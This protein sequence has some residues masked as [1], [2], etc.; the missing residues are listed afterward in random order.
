MSDSDW[1]ELQPVTKG[2]PVKVPV[3]FGLQKLGRGDGPAK[4]VLL[5]RR[6]CLAQLDLRHLRVAVRLGKGARAHQIALVP[7][8]DGPFEL[9][10]VGVAKGGGIYRLRL[11]PI[12]TF[13]DRAA[14]LI[15]RPFKIERDGKR[16]IIVVDLPSFCWDANARKSFEASR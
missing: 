4:G 10:E 12:D 11:P 6:D 2:A 3:R 1:T 13:P 8:D 5:I 9:Q 7:Q 16:Q 15:E 14:P